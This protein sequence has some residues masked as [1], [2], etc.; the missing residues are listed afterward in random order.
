M[1]CLPAHRRCQHE[2][3]AGHIERW[4]RV[5]LEFVVAEL[6]ETYDTMVEQIEYAADEQ[7]FD[8]NDARAKERSIIVD[9]LDGVADQL[10]DEVIAKELRR[11]SELIEQLDHLEKV[12]PIKKKE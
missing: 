10:D 5:C 6:S 8:L 3:G 9:Y 11:R 1:P 2:W 7:Q 4:C 12:V